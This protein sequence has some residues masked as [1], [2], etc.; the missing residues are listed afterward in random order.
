MTNKKKPDLQ[1]ISLFLIL[2][3]LTIA[4]VFIFRVVLF[5]PANTPPA[6]PMVESATR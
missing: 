3:F 5:V 1:T 2:A 4:F 6:A